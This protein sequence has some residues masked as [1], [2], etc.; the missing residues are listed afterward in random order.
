[1]SCEQ[2]KHCERASL[3]GLSLCGN[4]ICVVLLARCPLRGQSGQQGQARQGSNWRGEVQPCLLSLLVSGNVT[5]RNGQSQAC[6]GF[7]VSCGALIDPVGG[8]VRCAQ[9]ARAAHRSSV[10]HADSKKK[11][12][13]GETETH[14]HGQTDRAGPKLLLLPVLLP[15]LYQYSQAISPRSR[16]RVG[17]NCTIP[18]PVNC[19]Y[20]LHRY[21][22][23]GL[24]WARRYESYEYYYCLE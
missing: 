7:F 19:Y 3:M 23:P 8:K 15:T 10:S 6:R 11:E 2:A 12:S 13:K 4:L 1:M 22:V 18:N 21:T 14:R 5:G 24:F 17:K 20:I 9:H 16:S